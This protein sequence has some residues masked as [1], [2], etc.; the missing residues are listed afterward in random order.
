MTKTSP[1]VINIISHLHADLPAPS[2]FSTMAIPSFTRY[3][4][5]TTNYHSPL[6]RN[7]LYIIQNG[8]ISICQVCRQDDFSSIF[9][10][11]EPPSFPS[12]C[13]SSHE[14]QGLYYG[15]LLS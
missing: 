15:H 12:A 7:T 14:E 2:Y 11:T 3:W 6:S 9:M 5:D 1:Y 4:H 13:C 8:Y 10:Q